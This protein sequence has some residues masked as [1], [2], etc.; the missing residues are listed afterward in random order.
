VFTKTTINKTIVYYL[1]DIE[2][3]FDKP[4]ANKKLSYSKLANQFYAAQRQE[5]MR[6]PKEI[7]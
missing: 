5:Q 6:Q 3:N 4:E 7:K 2:C 1:L